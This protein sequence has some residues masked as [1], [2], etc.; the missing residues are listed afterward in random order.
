MMTAPDR[1]LS[2][3]ASLACDYSFDT[4]VE[5]RA[6]GLPVDVSVEVN[7]ARCE[8]TVTALETTDHCKRSDVLTEEQVEA[9]DWRIIAKR[10][11]AV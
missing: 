5:L 11:G 2:P 9:A 7:A 4:F 6:G 1:S 10:V 8:F 3:P